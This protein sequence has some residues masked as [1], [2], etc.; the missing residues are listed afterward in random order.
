MN[1]ALSIS[2]FVLLCSFG[3]YVLTPSTMS[4]RQLRSD[5]RKDYK[6]MAGDNESTSGDE[7]LGKENEVFNIADVSMPVVESD[8]DSVDEGTLQ[9]VEEEVKSLKLQEEK[10]RRK[11]VHKELLKEAE[12]MRRNIEQMKKTSKGGGKHRRQNVT[13]ASL[14]NSDDIT[15]EV[16]R[17]M[18]KNLKVGQKSSVLHRKKKRSGEPSNSSI[19]EPDTSSSSSTSSSESEEESSD[20]SLDKKKDRKQRKKSR[21]SHKKRKSGKSKHVTSCVKYTEKWP[22]AY[23]GSHLAS[24]KKRYEDLSLAEFVAGYSAILEES[25]TKKKEFRISHLKEL[26]YL[27]TKFHWRVV[28]QFHAACLLEIERGN[29]CWG[30]SF[31]NLQYATLAGGSL[32]SSTRNNTQVNSSHGNQ[33]AQPKQQAGEEKGGRILFCKPFQYG[34]C[35]HSQDHQG[36]FR[37][38]TC[39]LKHICA[40]CW[41][42]SKKISPHPESS[43][44]CPLKNSG[45]QS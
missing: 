33:Q 24:K 18:D 17:L 3:Q 23:L 16:D 36:L 2:R 25:S 28:L 1:G 5:T 6:K 42:H 20:S 40:N 4:D 13:T 21:K 26:M 7:D 14:R 44:S 37:G 43:E 41:L 8:S 38:E 15:R 34:F 22:Q 30:D 31:Q 10:Q 27:A 35:S 32:S 11:S 45:L 12:I 19:S 29:L 39:T 9:A